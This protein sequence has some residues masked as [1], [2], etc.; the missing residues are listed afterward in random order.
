MP[1]R[2]QRWISIFELAV[3]PATIKGRPPV[4]IGLGDW[5]RLMME[6]KAASAKHEPIK[7]DPDDDGRYLFLQDM[8]VSTAANAVAFLWT[9]GN[10]SEAAPVFHLPQGNKLRTVDLIDGESVAHS[11]VMVVDLNVAQGMMRYP[12]ALED[13]DWVS[14]TRV[15]AL[16]QRELR[17]LGMVTAYVEGHPVPG[18]PTVTMSSVPGPL[19]GKYPIEI[20][21]E[22]K[23]PRKEMV[24]YGAEPIALVSDR[25]VF[26]PISKQPLDDAVET[27]KR[28]AG[29]LKEDYPDRAITIRWR[30]PG[31][32]RVHK[33]SITSVGRA[34]QL[35][36]RAM[37]DTRRLTDLDFYV[38]AAT[39]TLDD[40]LVT[41]ILG[42]LRSRP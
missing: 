41:R 25:K 35:F 7:D 20:E 18:E 13:I 30:E 22:I 39:D 3:H 32:N 34:E 14:R 21:A 33:T 2:H 28:I 24:A 27:F 29:I 31:T 9:A 26:R 15:T 5:A 12:T 4:A 37:T 38:P 23:K 16:L 19:A 10:L 36:E 8:E 6:V 42:V 11:A 40:R 1:D 17:K